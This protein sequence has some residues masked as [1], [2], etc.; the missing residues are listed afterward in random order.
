MG[1]EYFLRFAI[2]NVWIKMFKKIEVLKVLRNVVKVRRRIE[3]S[4]KKCD[5]LSI[6]FGKVIPK[7]KQGKK[8]SDLG[9]LIRSKR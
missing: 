4:L 2:M 9:C 6:V 3:G 7:L 1:V 8:T 5:F